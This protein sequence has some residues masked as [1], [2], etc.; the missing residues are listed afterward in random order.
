MGEE[1]EKGVESDGY[2]SSG[3][4]SDNDLDLLVEQEA[5]SKKRMFARPKGASW[6]RRNL[7]HKLNDGKTD[8][9][10]EGVKASWDSLLESMPDDYTF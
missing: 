2:I 4:E 5:L 6:S 7:A 9:S 8:F 1:E 10:K 3:L